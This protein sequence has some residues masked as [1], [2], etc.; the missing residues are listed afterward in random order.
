MQADTA[1]TSAS[2][3]QPRNPRSP[4]ARRVLLLL[5][6][7]APYA[8]VLAVH[9]HPAVA[10]DDAAISFRYAERLCNGRGFTY[11][12]HERVH[13][14]SNP[15]YVLVF[16]AACRGGLPVE[17]AASVIGA[18][19]YAALTAI[20]TVLA[21]R[22]SG[23]LAALLAGVLIS[24]DA[25]LRFQMSSGMEVGL[26]LALAAAALLA[27]DARPAASRRRLTHGGSRASMCSRRASSSPW[28]RLR[29]CS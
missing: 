3:T 11:N 19:G 16:A 26:Q 1:V 29:P 22:T 20:A 24:S 23:L 21:A 14:A 28:P 12:D 10:L 18:L 9:A 27:I 15:F 7:L 8:I 6:L 13:G 5:A 2:T 17:A 4:P 25:F